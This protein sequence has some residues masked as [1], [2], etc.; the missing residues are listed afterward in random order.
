[1]AWLIAL[2]AQ[3]KASYG[4][5][6]VEPNG[7]QHVACSFERSSQRHAGADG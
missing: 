6:L 4:A 3:P 7:I 2:T 1:M 5:S